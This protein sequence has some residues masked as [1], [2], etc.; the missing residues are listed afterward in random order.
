M[1]S[2]GQPVLTV[3]FRGPHANSVW[4]EI[5]GPSDAQLARRTDPASINALYHHS[6]D[7]TLLYSPR[8]ASLVHLGL[9][10]WFGGRIAKN[11]L[12]MLVS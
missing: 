10:L 1:H 12:S 4:Q 3:A 6:Q 7:Q 2:E 11:T 8:L 9:C 5:A